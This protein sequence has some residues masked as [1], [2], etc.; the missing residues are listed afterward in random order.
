MSEKK[1]AV[2]YIF[3][4]GGHEEQM[5]RLLANFP[6]DFP[7]HQK[8]ALTSAKHQ[9]SDFLRQ[10]YC[11]EMRDKYSYIN[12]VFM[13]LLYGFI[14]TAQVI[15]IFSQ[16]NVVGIVSTGPGMSILPSIYA[17]LLG[18]KVVYFESWSRIYSPAI[19]GRVMYKIANVFY[20]QHKT[21]LAKYPKAIYAGRL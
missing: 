19:A 14:A 8:I 18:K 3:G 17:R 21:I 5:S 7:E 15:R 4:K 11:N 10:F 2:L 16:Y 9:K 20:V 13:M 12:S 1:N 6:I